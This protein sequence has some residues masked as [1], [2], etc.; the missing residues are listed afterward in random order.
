MTT[1]NGPDILPENIAS[2][3]VRLRLRMGEH[4]GRDRLDG[5]WWPQSRDLVA[6]L[7]DLVDHFPSRY[8][9]VVRALYS[10][11]DWEPAP[12]RV[13]VGRGHLK[14]G[15]FPRDDTHLMDLSMAQGSA[16]PKL[17]LLVVPPALPPRQAEE[18]LLT[19]ATPGNDRS[20]T[21]LLDTVTGAAEVAPVDQWVDDGESWWY[22]H[23]TAPSFRKG[24]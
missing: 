5:G 23:P 15:C 7:A 6:E 18:A 24:H 21:S 2:Q 8:G 10:P 4:P 1:S 13:P 22:P 14:V 11:P 12:R 20:A 19:A 16:W 17:R 3:R 9:R